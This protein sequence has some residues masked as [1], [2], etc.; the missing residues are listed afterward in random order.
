M[1]AWITEG[2]NEYNKRLPPE[3]CLKL[4]EITPVI[5]GKGRSKAIVTKE[6]S[7]LIKAAIP[8]GSFI[9]VLDKSGKQFN[10]IQ[11]AEMI[12]SWQQAGRDLALVIGGADGLGEALR[13]DADLVW[14]LSTLT[15]PHALIRV[16]L[17]EQFYRAWSITQGHPYHRE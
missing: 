14:S 5:R 4:T 9:I 11:L 2:F 3:L 6:E 13:N 15:L 1:P 17:A 16:V 8:Q 12:E 7:R 10:S